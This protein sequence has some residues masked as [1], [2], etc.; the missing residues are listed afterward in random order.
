MCGVERHTIKSK[1]HRRI[2]HTSHEL[3]W[4]LS[5]TTSILLR[6]PILP[7]MPR[8]ANNE[9]SFF[10]LIHLELWS[11]SV[12]VAE[13]CSTNQAIFTLHWYRHRYRKI[14]TAKT[15]YVPEIMCSRNFDVITRGSYQKISE[16][17]H[18]PDYIPF[19]QINLIYIYFSIPNFYTCICVVLLL[20]ELLFISTV[21]IVFK[22]YN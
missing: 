19:P 10:L 9:V 14:C 16:I 13:N 21:L 15:F 8:V 1:K 17:D 4:N 11:S 2:Y 22:Y 20:I 5:P 6:I 7:N 12:K 3:L 18:K